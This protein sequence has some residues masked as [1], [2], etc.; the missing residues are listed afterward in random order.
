LEARILG[1]GGWMPTDA[2]E[3]TCIYARDGDHVLVIDAGTGFRRL[4]TQSDLLDGV[5]SIS[6]VLS[7]FHIDHLM[8]L[9]FLYDL[10]HVPSREI[11]A[12]GRAL[13]SLPTADL[14]HRLVDP[15][16][17]PA[18]GLPGEVRELEPGPFQIGPFALDTRIQ[19]KHPNPTLAVKVNGELVVC[20][21]TEYDDGNVAFAR[22]ARVLCHDAFY[23][24]GPEPNHTR[25]EDAARL[26][27][28]AG[29]E[30]LVLIHLNPSVDEEV[31]L[32]AAR[33]IFAATDVGRDGTI[34]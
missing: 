32:R 34:L 31:V 5:R 11:W 24:G 19:R 23:V 13:E 2:R 12:A 20:T 7:H 26:A 18:S 1:S 4:V 21:D 17:M 9:P 14:V 3:T 15:P 30:R 22:G 28:E 29:V 6:V 10:D 33:P 25:V 16:F 8:G 27:G